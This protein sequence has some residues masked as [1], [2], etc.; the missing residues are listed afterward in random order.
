MDT[1]SAKIESVLGLVLNH[2]QVASLDSPLQYS[3][4]GKTMHL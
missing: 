3:L 2:V 1:R 4:I